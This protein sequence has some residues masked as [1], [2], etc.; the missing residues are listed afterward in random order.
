M[1]G[2]NERSSVD[3]AV[4]S[5]TAADAASDAPAPPYARPFTS[6]T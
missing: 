1:I 6:S 2:A 5:V 4:R 3:N